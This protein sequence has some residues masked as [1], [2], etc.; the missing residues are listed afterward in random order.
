MI[1]LNFM[2]NSSVLPESCHCPY[3]VDGL[4]GHLGGLLKRLLL[5]GAVEHGVVEL[6]A[7]VNILK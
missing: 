6:E 5:H 1:G 7:G 2:P 3:V 4:H